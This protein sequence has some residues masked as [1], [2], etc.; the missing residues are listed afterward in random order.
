MEWKSGWREKRNEWEARK[1]G[2]HI[3][4]TFKKSASSNRKSRGVQMRDSVDI[5]VEMVVAVSINKRH[6]TVLQS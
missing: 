4:M 1:W 5:A 6:L 2:Q 3:D